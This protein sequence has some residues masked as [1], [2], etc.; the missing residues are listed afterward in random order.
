MAARLE[1][2][3][4][5]DFTR[6]TAIG[7]LAHYISDPAVTAFQPMNINFGIIEPLQERVKGKAN[8][9]LAI[10]NRALAQLDSIL[11]KEEN[12]A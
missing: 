4:V 8:K 11:Q 7:A 3:S 5:P 2:K 6:R 9:N 10:A 12:E 1:G